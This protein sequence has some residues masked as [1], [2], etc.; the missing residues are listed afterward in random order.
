MN[1][2]SQDFA[3]VIREMKGME[4]IGLSSLTHILRGGV[5]IEKNSDLCYVD[6]VNW[7][8]IVTK[9]YH[10][11]IAIDVSTV[12]IHKRFSSSKIKH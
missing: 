6:T 10:S 2:F 5:R 4:E 8:A 1:E 3:L 9:K 11:L 12:Y 7:E